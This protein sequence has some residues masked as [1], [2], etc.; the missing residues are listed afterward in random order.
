MELIFL[1]CFYSYTIDIILLCVSVSSI[2]VYN[3][4]HHLILH[5]PEKNFKMTR[6]YGFYSNKS[7]PLLE[8]IYELYGKKVKIRKI[9]TSQERKKTSK[10]ET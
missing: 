9:K 3:F 2:G 7:R 5:C 10:K 6:Y 4:L 1:Y 8:R